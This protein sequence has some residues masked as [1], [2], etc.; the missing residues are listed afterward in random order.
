MTSG[1]HGAGQRAGVMASPPLPVMVCHVPEVEGL[2]RADSA[3][4]AARPWEMTL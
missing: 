3:R 1:L 4:G 2:L